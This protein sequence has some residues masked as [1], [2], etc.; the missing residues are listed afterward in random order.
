MVAIVLALV[1]FSSPLQPT[2]GSLLDDPHALAETA[3]GSLL[4]LKGRLDPA[5]VLALHLPTW[6]GLLSLLTVALPL[7][8]LRTARETAA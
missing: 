3:W 2:P 7:A 1:G 4:N 8:R 6:L 5:W